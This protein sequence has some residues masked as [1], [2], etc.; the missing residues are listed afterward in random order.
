MKRRHRIPVEHL[1]TTEEVTPE[2]QA[3]VDFYTERGQRE[4]EA[5]QRRL[6]AAL[7]RAERLAKR[8]AKRHTD[9]ARREID[10]AWALVDLRRMELG[11]YERLMAATGQ[12]SINRGTKSF[13]PVPVSQQTLRG[14]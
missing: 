1:R 11:K 9:K 3:E 6:T 8:N 4:Y 7:G 5:A 10:E 13:R 14:A 2:Y 12:P